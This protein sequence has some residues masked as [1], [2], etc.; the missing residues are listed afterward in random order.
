[1]TVKQQFVKTSHLQ[2]YM[3][4]ELDDD[5]VIIVFK[6]EDGKKDIRVIEKPSLQ[7]YVTKPEFWQGQSVNY[8]E[9]SKVDRMTCNYRNRYFEIPQLMG[10]NVL[11]MNVKRL[12]TSG[13]GDDRYT[14][15]KL[16]D[17][18]GRLHGTDVNIEDQY[19][20]LFLDK[21]KPEENFVSLHKGFFDIEVDM[22]GHKGFPDAEEAEFPVNMISYVDGLHKI[23]NTYVLKYDTE[24]YLAMDFREFEQEMKQFYKDRLDLDLEF[25]TREFDTETELIAA[26]LHDVNEE[27]QPDFMTAW[28]L[29]FDFPTVYNRLV[30]LGQSPNELFSSS[31]FPHKEAYYRLDKK[32]NDPAERDSKFVTT[33]CT[34]WVDQ[35]ALYANIQKP[36]GKLDSYTLDFVANKEVGDSKLEY[37]GDMSDAVRTNYRAFL[38]YNIHDTILQYVIEERAKNFDLL[39]TMAIMTHTRPTSTMKKTIS[40]RNFASIFYSSKGYVISNNRSKLFPEKTEKIPGGFVGDPNFVAKVGEE[41]VTGMSQFIHLDVTDIDL[42]SLYPSIIEALNI[43]PETHRGKIK[44]IGA[45]GEDTTIHFVDAYNSKDYIN[46]GIEY[47]GLPSPSDLLKKLGEVKA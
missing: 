9:E 2:K 38:H 12:F 36:K 14:A 8:I 3:H 39:Y 25:A 18:D 41:L 17:L 42:S 22:K 47:M 37:E 30:K 21:Y 34:N 6:K 28:N 33:S 46:F 27:Y 13:Y 1:M 40:L 44:Y 31:V 5:K 45:T 10:D 29:D 15:R 32:A 43:C 19:I 24:Q 20:H 7:F 26:F 11:E 4:K 23:V 16:V 35:L